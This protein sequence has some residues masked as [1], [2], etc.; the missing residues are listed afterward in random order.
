MKN[1]KKKFLI[2]IL[3][4]SVGLV[5]LNI[6][7]VKANDNENQIFTKIDYEALD[8]YENINE[9]IKELF[10][11]P[12]YRIMESFNQDDID[13]YYYNQLTNDLGR[14]IYNGIANS[15]N[16]TCV[17]ELT[18]QIYDINGDSEEEVKN[19]YKNNISPYITDAIVAYG[20]DAGDYWWQ[21][22]DYKV[23]YSYKKN[24]NGIE[25]VKLTFTSN[26]SEFTNHSAFNT[27]LQQ[28]S[29][30]IKGNSV[31]DMVKEINKYICTNVNYKKIEDTKIDQTAYGALINGESVCEGQALLFKMICKKKG[32]GCVCVSGYGINGDNKEAHEWNYVYEPID[33]KWYAVDVTWNNSTGIGSDPRLN[34]YIMVGKDT[35]INGK[36][37][38]DTHVPGLKFKPDQTY[39]PAT[40]TLSLDKYLDFETDLQYS[41]TKKTKN[42]VVVTIKSNIE[43]KSLTNWT[44]S[45][46]KKELTR[47][48]SNNTSG[49][50]TITNIYSENKKYEINIDNID[51]TAPTAKINMYKTDENGKTTVQIK[52]NEEIQ[53]VSGWNF[54]ENSKNIIEMS[55]NE[56]GI[57]KVTLV[58]LAGNEM[59]MDVNIEENPYNVKYS[60]VN[61]TNKDVT[62][63][64]SSKDKITIV[65]DIE[66]WN[67]TENKVQDEN[68]YVLTK[69][70]KENCKEILDVTNT[71][72]QETKIEVDVTN[73]DKK[74][75]EIEVKYSNKDL[76]N[77]DVKVEIVANEKI[78]QPELW[79][80]S[81]DELIVSK[82]YTKNKEEVIEV[83]DMAGN[84][85]RVNIKLENIDKDAPQFEINY[86]TQDKGAK[87]VEVLIF[88]N[89]KIQPVA[90]WE[91]S[92]DEKTIKKI[93]TENAV[94]Q[95]KI[96]DLIGNEI[97]AVVKVGNIENNIDETS[98]QGENVVDTTVSNK[99][100]PFTGYKVIIATIVVMIICSIITYKKYKK[101]Y[102]V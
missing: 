53:P 36:K 97:E 87:E 48:F 35:I 56:K 4:A 25:F 77:E 76:T 28:V 47:S 70:F 78:R 33:N 60:E 74:A 2:L 50:V 51:K 31:F 3:T 6:N 84:I 91:L 22:R 64:I 95:F 100:L 61:L 12:D 13:K 42:N 1:Y 75:P 63:T 94:D 10:D 65:N 26:I 32:I 86:S 96:R 54:V 20:L 5:F 55:F 79:S 59:T 43:L 83:S 23:S 68:E 44:L 30:S 27:K 40:P 45:D 21:A 9:N 52:T 85:T 15:S 66:G 92:K 67:L 62:V 46:D 16:N 14:T 89:E 73:I 57:Y 18:N 24:N 93:Y 38:G 98:I 101:Y 90:G 69:V 82:N 37:F 17:V 49:T 8:Y 88:S 71:Q 102:N 80:I 39:I 58:D 81:E 7:K 19:C 41:T 72:G 99:I 34:W 11:V 29:D